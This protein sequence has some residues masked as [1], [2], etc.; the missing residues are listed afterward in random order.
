VACIQTL[1]GVAARALCFANT[2]LYVATFVELP[3]KREITLV[4]AGSFIVLVLSGIIQTIRCWQVNRHLRRVRPAG[5]EDEPAF[6]RFFYDRFQSGYDRMLVRTARELWFPVRVLG[7]ALGAYAVAGVTLWGEAH[8]VR[9]FSA[10]LV[11]ASLS[12]AIYYLHVDRKIRAEFF[13]ERDTCQ[14]SRENDSP[15][16][17]TK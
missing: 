4:F 17:M 2:I 3:S 10:I 14:Q 15:T 6:W 8:L 11:V 13:T 5:Y 16:I 9:V 1:V 12:I 7:L